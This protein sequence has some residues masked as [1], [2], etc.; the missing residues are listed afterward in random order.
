MYVLFTLDKRY[1]LDYGE[2]ILT[3]MS[4]VDDARQ[5]ASVEIA[6]AFGEKTAMLYDKYF[7]DKDLKEILSTLEDLLA[8]MIGTR[9][10]Q[11]KMHNIQNVLKMS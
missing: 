3:S 4:A 8:R 11:E 6:N 2:T 1:V 7:V 9:R 5:I 10:T